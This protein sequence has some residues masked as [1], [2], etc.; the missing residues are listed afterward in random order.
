MRRNPVADWTIADV[1][2]VC[3]EFGVM[4]RPSRGGSSHYKL[5]HP[6]MRR[7]LTMPFKRPLR[8]VYIR[9]LV[10]FIDELR[11]LDAQP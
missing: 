2:A 4:C 8:P 6:R 10:A 11:T 1:E 5:G 7:K 9:Q 3:R